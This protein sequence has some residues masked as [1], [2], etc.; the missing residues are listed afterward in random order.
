MESLIQLAREIMIKGEYS[1]KAELAFNLK[2][3]LRLR[4]AKEKCK[5]CDKI[6]SNI[7]LRSPH[8]IH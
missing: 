7:E 5:P 6:T 3:A 2:Q 4:Y 1:S 8:Y